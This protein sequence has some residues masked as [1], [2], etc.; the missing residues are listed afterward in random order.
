VTCCDRNKKINV[1]GVP[2]TEPYL[3]PGDTP[4]LESF[5]IHVPAGRLWVMGDHRS[6]SADSRPHDE[7]TGGKKGSVPESLVVGRAISVVWPLTHLAWLANP[8]QTFD[9]VPDAR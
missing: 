9:K 7:G 1:N 8:T 3:F 4:S 2:L 5:D 6:D